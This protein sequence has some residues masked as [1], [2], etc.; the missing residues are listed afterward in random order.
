MKPTAVLAPA[1][2]C[3]AVPSEMVEQGR[4][5]LKT[6]IAIASKPSGWLIH[7]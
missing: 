6:F 4:N 5:D 3:L 7:P 1:R 2:A